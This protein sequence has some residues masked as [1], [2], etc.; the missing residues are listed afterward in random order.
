MEKIELRLGPVAENQIP[1]P[2]PL[3]VYVAAMQNVPMYHR[4]TEI[5][6]DRPQED[7]L[8]GKLRILY[9]ECLR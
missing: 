5:G 4:E 8:P 2:V 3:A 6:V 7:T 9:Q 1:S